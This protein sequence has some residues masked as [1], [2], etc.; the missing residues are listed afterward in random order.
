[1]PLREGNVHILHNF[2]GID[3]EEE[4]TTAATANLSA[5]RHLTTSHSL[6]QQLLLLTF[7]VLT[8]LRGSSRCSGLYFCSAIARIEWCLLFVFIFF[9][10][11]RRNDWPLH[12]TEGDFAPDWNLQ[13]LIST[14]SQ[15]IIPPFP[16]SYLKL[17]KVGF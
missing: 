10:N 2:Y 9:S 17:M 12:T 11:F 1:M 14:L 7:F 15:K 8:L 13:S 4:A 5:S 3:A 6:S 16:P